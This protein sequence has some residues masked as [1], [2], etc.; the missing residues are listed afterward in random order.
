M[1]RFVTFVGTEVTAVGDFSSFTKR[2]IGDRV[3]LYYFAK[4]PSSAK[5]A[6]PVQMW[7]IPVVVAFVG[8][9][10]YHFV[11][12][13]RRRLAQQ[14]SVTSERASP[15]PARKSVDFEILR[16]VRAGSLIEAIKRYR[17]LYGVGL[18]EAKD[19]VEAL[20]DKK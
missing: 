15:A 13:C 1:I 14:S 10:L 2:P 7:V 12:S 9:G 11:G 3:A 6:D 4:D 19:A 5:V 16:L 20:R 8:I 17:E 18:R